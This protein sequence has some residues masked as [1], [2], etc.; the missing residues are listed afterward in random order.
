MLFK[1]NIVTCKSR[2]HKN[3]F[4]FQFLIFSKGLVTSLKGTKMI[5]VA[6]GKSHGCA[7]SSEGKVFTFGV[8]NKGQCGR[9][10]P[11][12]DTEKDGMSYQLENILS[13]ENLGS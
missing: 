12:S 2:I 8:N 11:A 5:R 10:G 6:L 4:C 9:G 13:N 7:I 1:F 3:H